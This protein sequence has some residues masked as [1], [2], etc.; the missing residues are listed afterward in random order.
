MLILILLMIITTT[1][2]LYNVKMILIILM[3]IAIMIMI[4]VLII[5]R[6][7]RR[8]RGG[9]KG[10]EDGDDIMMR[11]PGQTQVRRQR[12]QMVACVLVGLELGEQSGFIRISSGL[13]S[14]VIILAMCLTGCFCLSGSSNWAFVLFFLKPYGLVCRSFDV[15]RRRSSSS[16]RERPRDRGR[17]SRFSAHLER[18][19][20]PQAQLPAALDLLG[21]PWVEPQLARPEAHPCGGE[22]KGAFLRQ[23]PDR[24]HGVLDWGG[25]P[26]APLDAS[27]VQLRASGDLVAYVKCSVTTRRNK[28]RKICSKL[29]RTHSRTVGALAGELCRAQPPPQFPLLPSP[30]TSAK[31]ERGARGLGTSAPYLLAHLTWIEEERL[32]TRQAQYCA[33][34]CN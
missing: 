16:Y 21:Q 10:N 9:R 32:G 2:I 23:L 29:W 3:T 7:R 25:S 18:A 30:G 28:G 19:A 33:D 31:R 24:A 34:A 15:L 8:R 22:R 4:V 12:D 14:Y 1:I 6:R 13:H 5:R 20:V 27:D 11:N 17:R 26:R